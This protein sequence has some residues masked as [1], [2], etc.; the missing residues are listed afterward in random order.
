M[1]IGSFGSSQGYKD[2]LFLLNVSTS[3]NT[4]IPTTEKPLRYVK[5]PEINHIFKSDPKSPS[6]IFSLFFAGAVLATLPA[7]LG[8]VS[9]SVCFTICN[10]TALLQWLFLGGNLN[11]LSKAFQSSPVSH[12]L[13][14]SSIVG[15]EGV[16]FLYYTRWN[17]FQTLPVLFGVGTITFLSGSRALSEVQER[18]LT[19]LR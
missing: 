16:L 6:V 4:P 10:L 12:T 8:F 1:V 3:G 14:Y 19:G 11:H 7:I 18:R 2:R 9:N 17:L 13:F 5:L 15:I